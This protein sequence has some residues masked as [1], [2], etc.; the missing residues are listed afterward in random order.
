MEKTIDADGHVLEPWAAWAGLPDEHRPQLTTDDRGLDH[1]H[2][3]GTEVFVARL[4]QMGTP[5]IDVGAPGPAVRSLV[6]E[7]LSATQRGAH[8]DLAG[9]T[10][11]AVT[12]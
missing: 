12:S 3:A 7:R 5:G 11:N 9:M 10:L 6:H 1:V 8:F 4:G 2:V